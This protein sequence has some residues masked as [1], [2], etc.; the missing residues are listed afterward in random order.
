MREKV[1]AS[2]KN[3]SERRTNLEETHNVPHVLL[4]SHVDHAI[5]LVE[6]EVLAAGEAKFPLLEH[7]LQT[8]GRRD[9]HVKAARHDLTL[10]GHVDSSDAEE[11][12]NAV[13]R[14]WSAL[15]SES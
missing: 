11:S 14:G 3:E 1:S 10:L 12:S 13:V 4:E 6:A 9:D 2:T 8:S 15:V 7:V 5:S